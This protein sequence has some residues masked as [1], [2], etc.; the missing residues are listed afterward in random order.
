MK[1]KIY[2]KTKVAKWF[3]YLG[4]ILSICLSLLGIY[5]FFKNEIKD[6]ILALLFCILILYSIFKSY[7]NEEKLYEQIIDI[8]KFEV[9]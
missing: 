7:K 3:I 5:S 1:L 2:Y 9:M 8:E 6:G 4:Y